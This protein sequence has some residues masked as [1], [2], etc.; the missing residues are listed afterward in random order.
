MRTRKVE[1]TRRCGAAVY[2]AAANAAN[3][4]HQDLPS[5]VLAQL[6]ECGPKWF[7]KVC[8]FTTGA[9]TLGDHKNVLFYPYKC[10][11]NSKKETAKNFVTLTGEEKNGDWLLAART[12]PNGVSES[13]LF[14]ICE[15]H[16]NV[17][18]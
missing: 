2:A 6:G 5:I 18:T 13:S 16:F 12:D 7:N 9:S 4:S 15:D 10:T 3:R 14:Y 1:P 8:I 17:S 11:N